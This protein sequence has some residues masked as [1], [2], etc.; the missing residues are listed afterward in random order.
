VGLEEQRHQSGEICAVFLGERWVE[1]HSSQGKHEKREESECSCW[2]E[3][4]M[5][6]IWCGFGELFLL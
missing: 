3:R 2:S 6:I 4:Q 5:L 1:S